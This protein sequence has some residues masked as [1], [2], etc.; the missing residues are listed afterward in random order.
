MA[1]L[2]LQS[3]IFHFLCPIK[4]K[5]EYEQSKMKHSSIFSFFSYL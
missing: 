1:A 4:N 2:P 3:L 5:I